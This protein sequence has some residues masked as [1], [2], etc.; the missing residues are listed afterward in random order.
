MSNR[1]WQCS[2]LN[3]MH[4]YITTSERVRHRVTIRLRYSHSRYYFL[5]T[6]VTFWNAIFLSIYLQAKMSCRLA[7]TSKPNSKYII[8]YLPKAEATRRQRMSDFILTVRDQVTDASW[9]FRW[10]YILEIVRKE[11]VEISDKID[12]SGKYYC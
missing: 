10:V 8:F 1:I 3:T 6:H 4:Y 7:I 9:Y 12:N 2:F 5:W 11:P